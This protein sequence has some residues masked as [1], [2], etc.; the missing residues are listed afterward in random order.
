VETLLASLASCKA[1]TVRMYADRKQW[2]L[3][4]IDAVARAAMNG[5]AIVSINVELCFVGT[6]STEQRLRLLE[7]AERCPVQ[8]ALTSGVPVASILAE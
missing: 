8:K 1:I 3:E 2:P 4:R 6:L 7:I 5:Y